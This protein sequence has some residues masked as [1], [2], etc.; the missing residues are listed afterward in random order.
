MDLSFIRL[1]NK[2]I[3]LLLNLLFLFYNITWCNSKHAPSLRLPCPDCFCLHFSH[4]T[5]GYI[6]GGIRRICVPI[7]ATCPRRM[8]VCR[9][10]EWLGQY[11]FVLHGQNVSGQ[12]KAVWKSIS[13]YTKIG[14]LAAIVRM[15]ADYRR[16]IPPCRRLAQ[17]QC[18]A[19]RHHSDCR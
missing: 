19:L 9:F 18:F 13:A 2:G 16:C 10:G 5:S 8:F 4:T 6:R 1:K 15:V 7:S 11:G 12:E 17:A 3:I 14:D